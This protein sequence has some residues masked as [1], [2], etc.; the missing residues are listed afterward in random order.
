M[1]V[2][3]A[4][5]RRWRMSSSFLTAKL[6]NST[7]TIFFLLLG[8]TK[9]VSGSFFQA[10][11]WGSFPGSKKAVGFSPHQAGSILPQ[12]WKHPHINNQPCQAAAFKGKNQRSLL[13][14]PS[15]AGNSL[16]GRRKAG[17]NGPELQQQPRQRPTQLPLCS[18]SND[19][20][21]RKRKEKKSDC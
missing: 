21:V 11:M 19:Q 3:Q 4:S 7:P 18:D 1:E 8:C 6:L 20:K 2:R 10:E 9:N 16:R 13:T 17:K 12:T 15:S 5:P 14:K